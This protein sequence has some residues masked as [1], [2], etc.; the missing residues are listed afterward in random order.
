MLGVEDKHLGR[1]GADTIFQKQG[2][3]QLDI[4]SAE[5]DSDTV[6]QYKNNW[7]QII[8]SIFC[9]TWIESITDS[10]IY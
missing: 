4:I 3:C 2:A 1:F 6:G 10:C 9:Y 7:F 5:S 8:I